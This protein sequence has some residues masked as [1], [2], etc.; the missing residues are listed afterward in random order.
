MKIKFKGGVI[1][2]CYYEKDVL[3]F[4]NLVLR[5]IF[6]ACVSLL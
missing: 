1:I 3:I 5:N 4:K 6:F 2:P